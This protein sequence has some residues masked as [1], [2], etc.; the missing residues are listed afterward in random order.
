MSDGLTATHISLAPK[1]AKDRARPSM[2]LQP[3]PGSRLLQ[4]LA[5]SM[6]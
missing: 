2:A 3:D 1:R 4:G 5:A 6:K